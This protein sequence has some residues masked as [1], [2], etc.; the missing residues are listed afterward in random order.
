MLS[1]GEDDCYIP[2][3]VIILGDIPI[4][5]PSNQNIVGDVS[6]ASPAGLTP[7]RLILI[8]LRAA[9]IND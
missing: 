1:L 9:E 8:L 4:D 2:K 3:Y 7:V 5:V 6:P